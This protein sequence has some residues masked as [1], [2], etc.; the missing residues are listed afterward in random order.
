MPLREFI[1]GYSAGAA[2]DDGQNDCAI[3]FLS[4]PRGG[5]RGCEVLD[6]LQAR[7]LRDALDLF[8]TKVADARART[9]VY[10]V[11]W[12]AGYEGERDL[13]EAKSFDAALKW[14]CD[15]Y[16]GDAIAAHHIDVAKDIAGQRSY[17]I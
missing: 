17:E 9:P 6:T 1:N 13:H 14:M 7:Q 11:V 5:T 3:L 8:L 16:D 10:V 2:Y 4:G 15:N 12:E